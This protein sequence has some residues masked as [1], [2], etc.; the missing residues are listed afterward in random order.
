MTDLKTACA[1]NMSLPYKTNANTSLNT[2]L[3]VQK[4][5][6]QSDSFIYSHSQ[7]S[8]KT[9]GSA[10]STKSAKQRKTKDLSQ[11]E[12]QRQWKELRNKRLYGN[13]KSVSSEQIKKFEIM[14]RPAPLKIKGGR[15]N[16]IG[17]GN[18]TL[19]RT[20]SASQLG[21]ST[22]DDSSS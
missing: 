22:F 12:Q 15:N 2:S 11:K 6:S 17:K 20:N 9:K 5:V 19:N 8:S 4:K 14:T 7:M 21:M 13:F 1:T 18:K 10:K 3:R 16:N